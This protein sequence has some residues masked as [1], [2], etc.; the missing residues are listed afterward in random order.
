MTSPE[1]QAELDR[2]YAA[3]KKM[4][5]NLMEKHAGE[6]ALMHG[7]KVVRICKRASAAMKLGKEQFPDGLF[8]IQEVTDRV[9]NLG[10]RSRAVIRA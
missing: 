2:N 4:P 8:S 5:P 9:I 3:F 7:G 6:F 10:L 1:K